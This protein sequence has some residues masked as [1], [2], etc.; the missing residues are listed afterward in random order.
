MIWPTPRTGR[1]PMPYWRGAREGVLRLPFCSLTGRAVWPP[2][3][4]CAAAGGEVE[5]RDCPRGGTVSSFSVVR[6]AVQPEWKHLGAYVVAMID[7]DAGVR[8]LSN[9][10]ACDAAE[11]TIGV[12]VEAIF[13]LTSDREL[14][15]PVFRVAGRDRP[16]GGGTYAAL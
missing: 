3:A 5:W 8:M 13:V 1:E 2:S 10:V 11:I 7:L 6:R 4:A 16:E 15:L 12:R 14:G 9:I